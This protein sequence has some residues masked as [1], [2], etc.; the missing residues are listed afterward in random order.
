MSQPTQ[1]LQLALNVR[2]HESAIDFYGKM[3]GARPHKRKPGYANFAVDEPALNH[4]ALLE[5]GVLV[6]RQ[7]GA[8]CEPRERGHQPG[9]R[10]FH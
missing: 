3:F 4:P 1:R 6:H 10:V 9:L 5:R 2:D 8:W 7:D